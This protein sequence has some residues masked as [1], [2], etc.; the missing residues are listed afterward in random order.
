MKMVSDTFKRSCRVIVYF[1]WKEYELPHTF[2]DV[3]LDFIYLFTPVSRFFIW[4]QDFIRC[5]FFR[6]II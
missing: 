3:V 6:N 4:P 2:V 5:A 1:G